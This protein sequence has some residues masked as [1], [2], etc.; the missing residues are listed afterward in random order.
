MFNV[1]DIDEKLYDKSGILEIAKTF[2]NEN[3][4]A[5]YESY[6]LFKLMRMYFN[7]KED[8]MIACIAD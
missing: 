6:P 1:E 7:M 3:D 5:E 8:D 4:N 2:V